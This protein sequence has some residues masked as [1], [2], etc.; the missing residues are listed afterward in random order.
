MKKIRL[1]L[2]NSNYTK[3]GPYTKKGTEIV[4]YNLIQ[5]LQK[6]NKKSLR[7]T[8]FSS[9]NSLLP[10]PTESVSYFSST[11]DKHIGHALHHFFEMSLISK[12]ISMQN[13]LD[14]FHIN[15]G[16]GEYILPFLQFIRK[17]VVIT[18]H[19]MTTEPFQ[20]KLFPIYKEQNFYKARFISISNFQ[21][22]GLPYLTY[23]RTIY[24]GI[25]TNKFSFNPIGGK[26]MIWT[27]RAI[28]EK[29]LDVVLQI[30][31]RMK[32]P[33]KI[34]PIIKNEYLEWLQT[35]VLKKRDTINQIVRIN[36]DF[37]VTRSNLVKEYQSSKL[38]LFP[39]KWEEPFGLT[40]IESMSCG[41][42]VVTFAK[43]SIPE[44]IKDGETGFI[45]NPS[46]DDIRG[47]WIIKKTGIEG[48]CEAVERI[49]SMP[50]DRYKEMRQAC[51]V[52]VE[53]NFTIEH[54]VD[55]YVEVYKEILAK[56]TT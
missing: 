24:H 50:E 56:K 47:N 41:T 32:K 15:L 31:K 2:I 4:V 48:L 54:M 6:N 19:G 26:Q 44:I 18:M 27:G 35:E 8:S 55:Q 51:R 16:N 36:F 20:K 11:E 28:P 30:A 7:L 5:E 3:I 40:L 9:G 37:N 43:G 46:D 29:G 42:P 12:A 23:L 21:R 45:I 1:G 22:K 38:F 49:Y 52:H 34:F 17:P 53:N 13:K 14:L 10:V 33:T 25:N 39:L